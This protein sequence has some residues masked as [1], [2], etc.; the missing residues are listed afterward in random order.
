M[1]TQRKHSLKAFVHKV[2]VRRLVIAGLVISFVLGGVVFLHE[3]NKVSDRVVS[4]A[5]QRVKLFNERYI[6][7]FDVPNLPDHET[8]QRELENFRSGRE[9]LDIGSFVFVRLYNSHLD[10]IA[11]VMDKNYAGIVTV[12][13]LINSSERWIPQHGTN[14]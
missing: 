8:I 4:V 5:L 3:R 10:T 11:E 6:Q 1:S 9:E 13:K 2:L 12:T 7:L 14:E